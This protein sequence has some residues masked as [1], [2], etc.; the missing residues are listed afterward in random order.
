MEDVDAGVVCHALIHLAVGSEQELL[1]LILGHLVVFDLS[2][3]AFVVYVV[4][5]ISY[6]QLCLLS[7]HQKLIGFR[8]GGV[9]AKQAVLAEHPKV[10]SFGEDRLP[11]LSLDIK[12]VLLNATFYIVTEQVVQFLRIKTSERDVK[13]STL[14]I[15]D[16]KS[17][18]VRIPFAADFVQGDVERFF[19]FCVHI[20]DN[21]INLGNAGIDEH[22]QALVTADHTSGLFIPYDRLHIAKLLNGAFQLFI[23][24]ISGLQILTGIVVSRE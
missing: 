19:F 2:G 21:D 15:C 10:A 5:R 3:S 13:V 4:G 24:W 6:D 18:F 20:N 11:Q 14:Q 16:H 9:A 17:Q 1:K 23:F 7:V 8:L 22:L 12:V